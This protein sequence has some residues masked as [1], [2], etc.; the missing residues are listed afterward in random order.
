MPVLFNTL[1][2]YDLRTGAEDEWFAGSAATFQDPV[3]V[4]RSADAPEGEGYLIALVN[5]I[6]E[7]RTEL[8]VLDALALSRGPIARVRV[9][10]C[11]RTGI[12]ATWLDGARLSSGAKP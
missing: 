2:R 11:L 7:R 12:H 8:I 6:P 4:P 10:V 1:R 9:P 3:Y 5:W